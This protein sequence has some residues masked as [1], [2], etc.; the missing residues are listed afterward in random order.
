[1]C[2]ASILLDDIDDFKWGKN[3]WPN[4]NSAQ[5]YEVIDNIKAEVEKACPLTISYSEGP[6]WPVRLGRRDGLIN[7]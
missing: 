1:G 3:A 2:Y 7:S 6:Y 4:R 5:G